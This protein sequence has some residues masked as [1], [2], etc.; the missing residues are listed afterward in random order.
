MKK[1][2]CFIGWLNGGIFEWEENF[3]NCLYFRYLWI[4]CMD[5]FEK[6]M[7]IIYWII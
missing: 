4:I 1:R 6:V 5:G 2:L 7:E 3:K